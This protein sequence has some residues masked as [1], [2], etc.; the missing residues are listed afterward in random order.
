MHVHILKLH[1]LASLQ[2]SAASLKSSILAMKFYFYTSVKRNRQAQLKTAS[3]NGFSQA[4]F[5]T[6]PHVEI[7][8]F[9]RRFF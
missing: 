1:M 4:V 6:K 8:Y 5:V 7:I 2:I 3:E 9:Y